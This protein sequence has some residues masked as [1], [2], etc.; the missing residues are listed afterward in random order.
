MGWTCVHFF[1]RK[2]LSKYFFAPLLTV[3]N[4]NSNSL[5]TQ[6]Q[7]GKQKKG[8]L[9]WNLFPMYFAE[10]GTLQS[11]AQIT[12]S[13]Q[14]GSSLPPRNPCRQYYL[15]SILLVYCKPLLILPLFTHD[16]KTTRA[17]P[18]HT[19]RSCIGAFYCKV[20]I[21]LNIL[22]IIIV[23]RLLILLVLLFTQSTHPDHL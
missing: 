13:K 1:E 4:L 5:R 20:M 9:D 18:L 11:H 19:M 12:T 21:N 3:L 22:I 2:I 7:S 10:I 8:A 16:H 14:F 17:C 15:I 6:G 23:I